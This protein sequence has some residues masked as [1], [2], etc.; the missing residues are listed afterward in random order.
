MSEGRLI[1]DRFSHLL[2][3]TTHLSVEARVGYACRQSIGGKVKCHI[4]SYFVESTQYDN[5]ETVSSLHKRSPGPL[6]SLLQNVLIDNGAFYKVG[7]LVVFG[8]TAL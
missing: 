4:F 3:T 1:R 6:R 8:L 7:W 2:G 5:G